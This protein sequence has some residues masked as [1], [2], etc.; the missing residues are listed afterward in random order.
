MDAFDVVPPLEPIDLKRYENGFQARL[1][2]E[3]RWQLN[4][5]DAS[6]RAGWADADKE[7]AGELDNK[8]SESDR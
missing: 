8:G 7:L 5:L 1:N 3:S 2:G 4:Q 6:W